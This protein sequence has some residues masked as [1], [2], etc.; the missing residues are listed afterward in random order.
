MSLLYFRGD[1]ATVDEAEQ[2]FASMRSSKSKGVTQPSQRR[3]IQYFR[4]VLV[5]NQFI[6]YQPIRLRSVTIAPLLSERPILLQIFNGVTD[7]APLLF[8]QMREPIAFND[9]TA[10]VKYNIELDVRGDLYFKIFRRRDKEKVERAFH[11]VMHSYFIS[12]T[13]YILERRNLDHLKSSD[14]RFSNDLTMTFQFTQPSVPRI[15]TNS[16]DLHER[17][18]RKYDNYLATLP[19][20]V[21]K[22]REAENLVVTSLSQAL[23]P[24]FEDATSSSTTREEEAK[25]V[26]LMNHP[27]V[28]QQVKHYLFALSNEEGSAYSPKRSEDENGSKGTSST[29]PRDGHL[30]DFLMAPP[31]EP[32]PRPPTQSSP[33][34]SWRPSRPSLG[35]NGAPKEPIPEPIPDTLPPPTLSARTLG[36]FRRSRKSHHFDDLKNVRHSSEANAN[37]H[38]IAGID[39]PSTG[40]GVSK[41]VVASFAAATST[42]PCRPASPSIGTAPAS[43]PA[44]VRVNTP[45]STPTTPAPTSRSGASSG[46]ATASPSGASSLPRASRFTLRNGSQNSTTSDVESPRATTDD[47]SSDSYSSSES[48]EYFDADY[49]AEVEQEQAQL[50]ISPPPPSGI[51]VPRPQ[52]E[53][54]P[55]KSK[56]DTLRPTRAPPS[57]A[58]Q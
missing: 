25:P 45:P 39:S 55:L 1:C 26:L 28:T 48:E 52:S 44:I 10:M 43:T 41:A 17:M 22:R 53:K 24:V 35:A 34:E 40:R 37:V 15:Y 2:L 29:S 38:N 57:P 58:R 18:A 20:S 50:A 33:Q 23:S 13:Q 49:I 14:R 5:R 30:D 56:V 3:Y 31:N 42:V 6:N 4:T 11:V 47:D 21:A 12:S 36:E 16:D 51:I 32:P 9:S 27:L 8:S 19:P 46:W 54:L 7:D